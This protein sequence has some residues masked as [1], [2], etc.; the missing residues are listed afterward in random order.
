MLKN[1][2]LSA[3][4]FDPELQP[5]AALDPETIAEYAEVMAEAGG[6]GDFPPVELV[7][8]T[9]A[10]G[11]SV[12]LPW[13]GWHRLQAA[14]RAGLDI[15]PANVKTGSWNDALWL[16]LSA[17]KT[18]GLRRS[19]A[20]RRRAVEA[21]LLRFPGRSDREIAR[22]V[23]VSHPT[24]G[25]V[26]EELEATGKIYQSDER[27]GADGRAINTANIGNQPA[28]NLD[29]IRKQLYRALHSMQGASER[30]AERRERGL[31]DSGLRE[32][33]GFEFGLSGIM[34]GPGDP[35]CRWK[36]R[37][38]PQFWLG[39]T[40]NFDCKPD[41]QGQPLL[42]FAREVLK[43]PY[44]IRATGKIYQSDERLS[45]CPDCGNPVPYHHLDDTLECTSC[46]RKWQ[47]ASP[48]SPAPGGVYDFSTVTTIELEQ[49]LADLAG[50]GLPAES[51]YA[52][53]ARQELERRQA[54]A[55]VNVELDSQRLRIRVMNHALT[56]IRRAGPEQLQRLDDWLEQ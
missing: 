29:E 53:R 27:T 52:N 6:W 51:E 9:G 11:K 46:G 8:S 48:A 50:A 7:L 34:S 44:P 2:S 39:H 26:R 5:R 35:G 47:I 56:W 55:P 37:R 10:D 32:A 41:L 3:I 15:V 4:E 17:N 14:H 20:D 1:V 36:G 13:D 25:A 54:G 16:S 33:I 18:H 42:D 23:G 21:A 40:V 22:H 45:P 28:N 24:V 49:S 19:G 12:F 38:D 43:I 30:W 31:N